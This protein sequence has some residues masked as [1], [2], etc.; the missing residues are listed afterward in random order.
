MAFSAKVGETFYL[1]DNLDSHRHLYVVLTW[2][3]N[4]GKVVVANFTSAK[5]GK[6]KYVLF[7]PR[8]DGR[9]F[10][11]DTTVEYTDASLVDREKLIKHVKDDPNNYGID[12]PMDIVREVV[13]GAFRAKQSPNKVLKELEKQYPEL[14]KKYYY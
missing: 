14:Y 2:P 9:L 5:F 11:K 4:K 13:A 10:K 12:C 7:T 6:Q 1:K 3:D 8:D